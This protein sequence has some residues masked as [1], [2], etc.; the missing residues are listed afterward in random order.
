MP[1]IASKIERICHG[2]IIYRKSSFSQ[3]RKIKGNTRNLEHI[4]AIND[5]K[6]VIKNECKRANISEK[7]IHRI[8]FEKNQPVES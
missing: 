3:Y 5:F 6:T 8:F 2:L 1:D 4:K 7:S